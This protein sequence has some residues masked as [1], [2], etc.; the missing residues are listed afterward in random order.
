MRNVCN[1]Q[2]TNKHGSSGGQRT[3]SRPSSK[4]KIDQPQ[5]QKPRNQK[6]ARNQSWIGS[7]CRR[8]QNHPRVRTDGQ[9]AVQNKAGECPWNLNRVKGR[10]IHVSVMQASSNRRGLSN[11]LQ[12]SQREDMSLDAWWALAALLL[13][14]GNGS[15]PHGQVVL[16]ATI[17]GIR[18]SGLA[19]C[20]RSS[21][22]GRLCCG[23]I[24]PIRWSLL[25]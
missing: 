6:G 5:G 8:D 14:L 3:Q 4:T 13:L 24:L 20:V 22:R 12:S 11:S 25:L 1:G 9:S 10:K 15:I 2:P 16:I 7:P 17:N 23:G 18:V 21:C 19:T